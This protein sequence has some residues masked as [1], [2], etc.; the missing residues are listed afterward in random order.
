MT[1]RKPQTIEAKTSKEWVYQHETFF[2]VVLKDYVGVIDE[3][4]EEELK[5]EMLQA[6]MDNRLKRFLKRKFGNDVIID[7]QPIYPRGYTDSV[8]KAVVTKKPL[9]DRIS[10]KIGK[11]KKQSKK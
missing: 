2:K 10:E 6:L 1:K 7:I 11:L 8:V 3:E 9:R 4:M 5:E